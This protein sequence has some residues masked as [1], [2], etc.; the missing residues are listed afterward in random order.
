MIRP[1]YVAALALGVAVWLDLTFAVIL[2]IDP[3]GVSPL[4]VSMVGVNVLKPKRVDID[5]LIRPCEV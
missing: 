4:R 1:R 3:Y 5:R 2:L